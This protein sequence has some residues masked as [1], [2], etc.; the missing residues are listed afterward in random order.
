MLLWNK[1]G[2]MAEVSENIEQTENK[3]TDEFG[4]GIKI[5]RKTVI[6]V[7]FLILAVLFVLGVKIFNKSFYK[8]VALPDKKYYKNVVEFSYPKKWIPLGKVFYNPNSIPNLLTF[9]VATVNPKEIV[10]CQFF[11]T[12]METDDGSEYYLTKNTAKADPVMYF[13]SAIMKMSP[14]AKDLK[15]VKSYKPTYLELR[16]AKLDKNLLRDVY[17]DSNPANDKGQSSLFELTYLPV[18]YLYEYVEDGKTI[19]HLIEGRFVFFNQ[20]YSKSMGF[21][22]PVS[23]SIKFVR[24]ENVFSYKAEKSIYWKNYG[25]YKNFKDNLKINDEWE[26]LAMQERQDILVSL[27]KVTTATLEGGGKFNLEGFKN[28]VYSILYPDE[29]TLTMARYYYG[30]DL[31]SFFTKWF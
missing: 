31:K 14:T 20:L 1:E 9:F 11:S 25:I 12:Q 16:R 13:A 2:Y 21:N 4:V 28:T 15:L 30:K 19:H 22:V 18:H 5:G 17:A 8:T 7:I 23:V 26:K 6:A 27:P 10:E 24:C 29:E 3:K